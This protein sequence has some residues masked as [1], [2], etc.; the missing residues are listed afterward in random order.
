MTLHAV[1]HASNHIDWRSNARRTRTSRASC[2][3]SAPRQNTQPN[4][5]RLRRPPAL[6]MNRSPQIPRRQPLHP[7]AAALVAALVAPLLTTVTGACIGSF[8]GSGAEPGAPAVS[9]DAMSMNLVQPWAV[10]ASPSADAVYLTNSATSQVLVLKPDGT[11]AVYAGA[12]LGDAGDGDVATIALMTRPHALLVLPNGDLL[13]ADDQAHRVRVVRL[14]DG[15]IAAFAGNGTDGWGGDGLPATASMLSAPSGLATGGDGA[16]VVTDVGLRRVLRIDAAGVVTTLAGTGAAPGWSGDGGPATAA[17]LLGP[18]GVAVLPGGAVVFADAQR[19]AVTGCALRIVMPDG[20]IDS[21]LGSSAAPPDYGGLLG[22][23]ATPEGDIFF[24]D[25][26]RHA[27]WVRRPS[28]VVQL[29]AGVGISGYAGDGGPATA[30]AISAPGMLAIGGGFLFV[31]EFGGSM[32]RRVTLGAGRVTGAIARVAGGVPPRPGQRVSSRSV[33]IEDGRLAMGAEGLYV[34][35]P[36]GY[37]QLINTSD[38]TMAPVVGNGLS[39]FGGD[40]GPATSAS[41]QVESFPGGSD[42]GRRQSPAPK[43]GSAV[44]HVDWKRPIRVPSQGCVTGTPGR[45]PRARTRRRCAMTCTLLTMG[46]AASGA[47]PAPRARSTRSRGTATPLR[48]RTFPRGRARGSP[49]RRLR[50]VWR[51]RSYWTRRGTC[52]SHTRRMSCRRRCATSTSRGRFQIW[53]RSA[54]RS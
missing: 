37:V 47:C 10:A 24:S 1:T 28:G 50:S 54:S 40:G 38:W 5:A 27:V 22:V 13:V 41:I 43:T 49:R 17:V 2:G 3:V 31:A 16:V 12:G 23:V 30:A 20:V 34:M 4:P 26:V 21:L 15:V 35:T 36:P 7:A 53:G 51:R 45:S 46:T 14:Q 44:A 52:I 29:V 9:Q 19:N 39:S 6:A 18:R 25:F 11:V 48:T 33:A 42:S 8:T 32:V